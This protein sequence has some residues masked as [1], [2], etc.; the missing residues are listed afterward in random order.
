MK[1]A[2]AASLVLFFSAL[3]ALPL[4]I[5]S[6]PRDIFISPGQGKER[7]P[8][9]RLV[10]LVLRNITGSLLFLMGFIMLFIPG[11]GI[12]TMLAGLVLMR[13][14]GKTFLVHKLLSY[15]PVQKGLNLIRRRV[16]REPFLFPAQVNSEEDID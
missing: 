14:P 6:L 12:L 3:A 13:F 10:M 7:H 8:L 5:R 4:I 11:Q 16:G 15:S 2:G 9:V 1:I